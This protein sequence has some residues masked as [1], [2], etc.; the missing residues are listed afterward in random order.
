MN[1][2]LFYRAIYLTLWRLDRAHY[3][4]AVQTPANDGGCR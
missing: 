4:Y 1:P 3:R 2:G